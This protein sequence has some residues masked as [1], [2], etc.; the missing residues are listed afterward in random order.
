[1]R[2]GKAI[3]LAM[4]TALI[5][6]VVFGYQSPANAAITIPKRPAITLSNSNQTI[7]VGNPILPVVATN[8]GGALTSAFTVSPNPASIGL[9]FTADKTTASISGTP[10]TFVGSPFTFT[11]SA[12]YKLLG[13]IPSTVTSKF[14][15]TVNPVPTISFVNTIPMINPTSSELMAAGITGDTLNFTMAGLK[16]PVNVYFGNQT[17]P[18]LATTTGVANTYSVVVPAGLTIGNMAVRILDGAGQSRVGIF[19]LWSSRSEP[20][21]MPAGHLNVSLNDL[22]IILDNIKMSE[23]HSART[24]APSLSPNTATGTLIYPYDVTSTN[25]CLSA[26]DVLTAATSTFGL[27]GLSNSYTWTQVDPLGVRQVDGQCNNITAVKAE[28]GSSATDTA[29]WGA[30][31]QQFPRI[32]PATN[33]PSTPYALSD[34]QKAYQVPTNNVIDPTPRII[35][36]LI[37]DQTVANPAAV[38]AANEAASIIYG[39]SSYSTENS[40]NATT[41]AVT[42]VLQIPNITAD[43]NVSAGYN[44]WFTLFGQFF[45]HGL[46]LI[47]KAGASVLIPL[48]QGDPLYV[49]SPNAPNFMVLTRGADATGNSMNE[50]TP[51]VDQSQTYGS[52]PSQNFFLREYNFDFTAAKTKITS[53]GRLIEGNDTSFAGKVLPPDWDANPTI[54]GTLNQATGAAIDSS[55]GGLPT[56]QIIKAQARLLG[57]NLTDY[58][59]RSIP[60]I[61]T[62]QYGKFIP[63]PTGYPM[64]LFANS[65]TNQYKWQEGSSSTPVSTTLAGGWVAVASGHTFLND[66][67]AAAV[68]FCSDGTRLTP[69]ADSIMNSPTAAPARVCGTGA[70]YDDETLNAHLIAGDGRV[71]ENIGLSAIHH[72]FHSE[73]NL[74]VSDISNLLANDPEVTLDF[75]NEWN[76]ERLY[77]AARFVMEMEYQHM[78]YDE[79]IRRIAPELPLFVQYDPS[80]NPDI[81]AEFAS[82]VYRLGH[83][84]LNETIARSNPGTYYDPN[85][86]QDVSLLTAFTNPAQARLARPA[87]IVSASYTSPSITYTLQAGEP[88]PVAGQIVSIT[89]M[90]VPA[91]NVTDGVVAS[92]SGSTFKVS[93]RYSAGGATATSLTAPTPTTSISKQACSTPG[94][95]GTCTNYAS[96][97]ISDPGT[98]GYTY[99]PGSS[100]AAIAQGMSSQRGNEIDEFVTD[101]VRNNLLGLPLDLASLNITR[102]RDTGLPTFNQF[103]SQTASLP[104]Y[105]SWSDYLLNLRHPESISNFIAAYG[106]HDSLKSV[107]VATVT[108]ATGNATNHSITYATTNTAG[109]LVGDVVSVTGFS[110][111]NAA[112]AIVDSIVPN[113]S[114]TVS[115]QYSSPTNAVLGYEA[116]D[117]TFGSSLRPVAITVA[118]SSTQTATPATPNVTRI[119]TT[120]EQ[121]ALGI[122]ITTAAINVSI[123]GAVFNANGTYTFTG[124]NTY[125]IGQSINISGIVSRPKGGNSCFNLAK[126][127]VVASDVSSF[128]VSNSPIAGGTSTLP[129][130]SDYV[131]TGNPSGGMATYIDNGYATT[132]TPPTDSVDFVRSTGTWAAKESGINNVDLWIGGLAEIPRKQPLT[133][134]MLGQTFQYVFTKQAL[135][136]QN[137]DRFYYVGRLMGQN[138]GEEIPAQKFTDMVRRNTPSVSGLTPSATTGI[139]GMVS[140]GFGISDC[141]WSPNLVSQLG[142]SVCSSGT[143]V[144]NNAP[145]THVGLDN[146]TLFGNLA[147]TVGV[148]LTGGAGDDSIQGTS[149]NDLLDGGISG[150]D[151]IYGYS[152]NDI[153]NGGAGE[154]LLNGGSGDDIINTGN[155]QAGDIADG[156]TGSDWIDCGGCAGFA[157]S[158][159]GETGN[160]FIQGGVNNDLQLNGGEGDDWLEGISGLDVMNGDSGNTTNV[161]TGSPYINGG[162]DVL[163][164]GTGIG[165]ESGD[166]GDDI[167]LLGKGSDQPFGSYGF[168][169]ADYEYMIRHDVTATG[170]PNAFADL[171][172][173]F[174]PIN[175]ARNTDVLVG[176][177]GVSGSTGDDVLI[178]GV[179]PGDTTIAAANN[180]TYGNTRSNLLTLPGSYNIAVG[181]QVSGAGI[182]PNAVVTVA[183]ISAGAN[184]VTTVRLSTMNTA[185][186]KG[187]ILI[188]TWPLTVPSLVTGLT[189]LVTGTPGWTKYS[190]VV[191][192]ATKWSGGGILLGGDG[193]DRIAPS[194]GED[195]IHGSAYLHTCFT[196]TAS[197]SKTPPAA[198]LSAMDV[199]CA[200]GRGFSNMT[201]AEPFMHA[202]AVLPSDLRIVREILPTSTPVTQ[203]ATTGTTATYTAANTF[204]VGEVVTVNGLA[205]GATS[206]KTYDLTNAVVTA[207]TANT[208]TVAST[209]GATTAPVTGITAGRAFATN[210]L[211]LSGGPVNTIGGPGGAGGVTAANGGLSGPESQFTFKALTK[212]PAGASLGCE[213]TDSVSG[214]IITAYDMALVQFDTGAPMLIKN[215]GSTTIPVAQPVIALA[216]NAI[217][218]T[219]GTAITPVKPTSTGGQ[220]ATFSISPA[221]SA[222]LTFDT[223]TGTVAGTPTT[224]PT[225]TTNYTI[226]A[227]NAS[228]TTTV[229]LKITIAALT[230][231]SITTSTPTLTATVG[232]PITPIT[233]RNTGGAAASYS[234]LP[235][236]PNALVMDPQTGVISGTP[237]AAFSATLFTI[238]ATNA[239]GTGTAT[240]TISA[241]TTPAPTT[242]PI[243]TTSVA[244]QTVGSG[245]AITPVTIT[246][247]GGAA[248]SFAIL[249]TPLISGLVFDA[250]TGTLSGTPVVNTNT[251]VTYR[252]TATNSAG[253]NTLNYTLS[254]SGSGSTTPVTPTPIGGNGGGGSNNGNQS[255]SNFAITNVIPTTLSTA[256]AVTLTT[257]GGTASVTYTTDNNQVCK[258]SGRTLTASGPAT[259]VVTATQIVSGA[260]VTTTATF[261]FTAEPQAALR[262]TTRATTAKVGRTISLVTS[263]GSGSGAVTYVLDPASSGAC[264]LVATNGGTDLTAS[265][266]GSCTVIAT[267]AAS[268]IYAPVSSTPIVFTFN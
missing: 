262:I 214:N 123:T 14:K 212:L 42:S 9:T 116:T 50:T 202:G 224:A 248:T 19:Q 66:T 161:I 86:N 250:T 124:S 101:A 34:A 7:T 55:N 238:T 149:G 226:T 118:A 213:I 167:F 97:S 28:P 47:P 109:I 6:Q 208:F 114:F 82:A 12:P 1:M 247:T 148:T 261:T 99:T 43:Y 36:N 241:G 243:L 178:G 142:V 159:N 156:G 210:T 74:L 264:S 71:N 5:S 59:V 209:L 16:A 192:T 60:V 254:V 151:L 113:T 45:D 257:N 181:D 253:S 200:G 18:V 217:T 93:T 205:A 165:I 132:P 107:N 92:V 177:E 163:M 211:D 246:N 190:K 206:L 171:S 218:A 41:G 259:C 255:G 111:Y 88:V 158:F 10:K 54:G 145:T 164:S 62:D 103:R 242:A 225:G 147:S 174:A 198:M 139:L 189:D 185:A 240:V 91:F 232:T 182:G 176:F 13:I 3:S 80:K 76:G 52:H 106:T 153:I 260:P 197:P 194:N 57:F 20:Y 122:A 195:I 221:L 26:D 131:S 223:S 231:P 72:V 184:P 138:L 63:G 175:T 81:N 173:S 233:P 17:T 256:S 249:P 70:T 96:V 94:V 220:V 268:L 235:A 170:L 229:T 150:G 115:T 105:K 237:A 204:H 244:P 154:D 37:S 187:P 38:A 127:T 2:I 68:P 186:V 73:H 102:G 49:N 98:A 143:M 67:T 112:N 78:A 234:I 172:G 77:Q 166:G 135:D 258:I 79:F 117:P 27:T 230:K 46:D 24:A 252:I 32:A 162:N 8:T 263:G 183:T 89:N 236:L 137:S 65:G 196:L 22:R 201:A 199:T 29:L 30:A 157:I 56:W 69:D 191:P 21:V 216:N 126:A 169:W 160:D 155:N 25:R 33:T 125:S 23:A 121:R 266:A 188:T 265:A 108:S 39:S 85:N 119:P 35:S 239:S 84:M 40:I 193:N 222:G 44:S 152:G 61:A 104:A 58:D 180:T 228:G 136:L 130:C 219:V 110:T 51:Y 128:T 144:P 87:I 134:P 133:P 95:S 15:L 120:A 251:T 168:D 215:C 4:T 140:P 207:A 141:A 227:T 75:R 203:V 11:I 129:T 245:L 53:T 83:S 267:K 48:Q 179:L 100:A 146:V 31:D 64:M 90:D